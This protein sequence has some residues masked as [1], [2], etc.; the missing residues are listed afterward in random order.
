[1]KHLHFLYEGTQAQRD[2]KNDLQKQFKCT[3]RTTVYRSLSPTLNALI[4]F[5]EGHQ[6][7]ATPQAPYSLY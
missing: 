1:M 6:F 5:V 7:G 3:Q 4:S 2:N